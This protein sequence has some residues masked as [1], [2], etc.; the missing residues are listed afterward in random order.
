MCS[1]Y[2]NNRVCFFLA[3]YI[4]RHPKI[5]DGHTTTTS[6]NPTLFQAFSS[7][8]NPDFK[9]FLRFQIKPD[10]DL[11]CFVLGIDRTPTKWTRNPNYETSEDRM[12]RVGIPDEFDPQVAS[13]GMSSPSKWLPAK[14]SEALKARP[15]LIDC[16][17]V[18]KERY[19][20]EELSTDL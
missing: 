12:A 17:V 2:C 20:E 15:R 6:F 5:T 16:F 11:V 10:G 7:L 14:R 9:S 1:I 18:K 13:F 4:K 19:E 8:R 3:K